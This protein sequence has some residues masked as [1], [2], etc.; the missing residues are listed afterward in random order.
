MISLWDANAALHL[1]KT[2]AR[3][4]VQSRQQVIV[5]IPR[6]ECLTFTPYE[7]HEFDRTPEFW[8]ER[9]AFSGERDERRDKHVLAAIDKAIGIIVPSGEMRR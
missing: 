5:I 2:W 6:E 3:L 1:L 7:P 9:S 4:R 8:Y